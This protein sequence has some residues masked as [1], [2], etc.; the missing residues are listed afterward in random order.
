MER[1]GILASPLT[2]L[3]LRGRLARYASIDAARVAAAIAAFSLVTA[4][5]F[6]FHLADQ[7]QFIHLMKNVALGG[8]F[9]DRLGNLWSPDMPQFVQF[10]AQPG[11]AFWCDQRRAG[12]AGW[13]ITAH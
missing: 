9:A 6:H 1:I 4:F 2:D 7:N 11:L 13:A 8:G 10:G 3:L 12:R 5:G